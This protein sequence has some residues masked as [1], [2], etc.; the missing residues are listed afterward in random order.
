MVRLSRPDQQTIEFKEALI[1]ALL[2]ALRWR[3]EAR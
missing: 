2:A 1:M 3:G